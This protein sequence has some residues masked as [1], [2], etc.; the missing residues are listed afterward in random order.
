MPFRLPAVDAAGGWRRDLPP[1]W[2]ALS[3]CRGRNRGPGGRL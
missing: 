2:D 3:A 1:V